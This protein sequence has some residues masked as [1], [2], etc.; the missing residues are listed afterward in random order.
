MLKNHIENSKKI[1]LNSLP[2]QVFHSHV[3]NFCQQAFLVV[4]QY[5]S[6]MPVGNFSG[7]FIGY[8]TAGGC[9]S[10]DCGK[11][12]EN[13]RFPVENLLTVD[14]LDQ[15]VDLNVEHNAGPQLFLDHLNRGDN[16]GVI[17]AQQLSYIGQ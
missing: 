12:V 4:R 7:L 2:K 8:S 13:Y 5:L 6:V 9:R 14:F 16:G 1:S 3:E 17:S 10:A 11:P 15:L